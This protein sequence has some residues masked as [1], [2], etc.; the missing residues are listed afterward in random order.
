VSAAVN[1]TLAPL[2]AAPRLRVVR[3]KPKRAPDPR[4]KAWQRAWYQ[5]RRARMLAWLGGVCAAPGCGETRE[6]EIDHIDP[7]AKSCEVSALWSRRWAVVV[8]ELEKC[9]PLCHFHHA[10]KT[11]EQ[12]RARLRDSRARNRQ[13]AADPVPF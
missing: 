9:Q 3:R 8:A 7:R 11:G 2:R 10:H 5:T 6:L 12:R 1:I 4:Q 13:D